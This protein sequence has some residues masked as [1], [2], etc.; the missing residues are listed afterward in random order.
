MKNF[1][2]IAETPEA[3]GAFLAALPVADGPWNTEFHRAFCDTCPAQN[4]DGMNCPHNAE[5]NNPLWWLNK[6]ADQ[7]VPDF[8]FS[9]EDV[10]A[11]ERMAQMET[12]HGFP[13]TVIPDEDKGTLTIMKDGVTLALGGVEAVILAQIILTQARE[14]K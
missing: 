3:L 13:L 14:V 7:D 10:A 5:R 12:A 1:E 2:R 8:E 11:I 4:C 6:E 9:P